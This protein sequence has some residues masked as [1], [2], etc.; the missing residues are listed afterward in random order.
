MDTV[1]VSIDQD[2]C[3]GSGYCAREHPELFRMSSDGVA[4]LTADNTKDADPV[5]IS[6]TSREAA[7]H[8]SMICPAGAIT[9]TDN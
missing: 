4:E 9:A 7:H 5:R 1:T 2:L 6:G 3:M 8:A